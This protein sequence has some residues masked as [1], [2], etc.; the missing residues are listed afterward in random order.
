[1]KTIIILN[2]IHGLLELCIIRKEMVVNT[3]HE[4]N[5]YFLFFTLWKIF[6]IPPKWR[7]HYNESPL[8]ITYSIPINIFTDIF[9]SVR[10]LV[11]K[12]LANSPSRLTCCQH[13]LS[14]LHLRRG[15]GV[16]FSRI[17]VLMNVNISNRQNSLRRSH[18]VQAVTKKG[19]KWGLLKT[20][21]RKTLHKGPKWLWHVMGFVHENNSCD[22]WLNSREC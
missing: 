4:K 6:K 3:T 8:T 22:L 9:K 5:T 14:D 11:R 10:K 7:E 13:R 18:Y 16:Q 21:I 15:N 17:I 12:S 19:E 20:R 2:N 1:M